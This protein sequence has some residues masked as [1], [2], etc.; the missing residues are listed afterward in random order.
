MFGDHY[1]VWAEETDL[2]A[3]YPST[4]YETMPDVAD[5]LV[6]SGFC[7]EFDQL[8]QGSPGLQA[9]EASL[10]MNPGGEFIYGVWAQWAYE[11]EDYT[12]DITESDAMA[13]RVWYIDDFIPDDAWV[14]GGGSN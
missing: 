10:E 6:G 1:Q 8:D 13:R 14:L 7:N 3:C 11:N 9:S 5:E 4:T 2:D 12:G